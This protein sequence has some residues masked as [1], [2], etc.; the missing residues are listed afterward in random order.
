MP[1]L[2]SK[3]GPLFLEKE[4]EVCFFILHNH[5][6][7]RPAVEKQAEEDGEPFASRMVKL[8]AFRNF[9]PSPDEVPGEL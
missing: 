7:L 9:Q 5:L 4:S 2:P 3:A 6:A 1:A 8:L